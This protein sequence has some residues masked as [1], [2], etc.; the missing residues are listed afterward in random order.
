MKVFRIK[1]NG[2]RFDFIEIISENE[3]GYEVLITKC[4]EDYKVEKNDF[5]TV[6]LWDICIE[7]G[8]FVPAEENILMAV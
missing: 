7:T 2:P 5:I 3:N 6:K 1:G 8:Y 4:Y